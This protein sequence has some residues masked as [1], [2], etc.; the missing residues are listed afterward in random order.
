MR[1]LT[2]ADPAEARRLLDAGEFVWLDLVAP[3]DEELEALGEVLGLHPLAVEDTRELDQ[4]PKTDRYADGV[5]FVFF[6]AVNVPAGA[7]VPVEVHLH[8]SGRHL[9]T[10]RSAPEPSLDALHEHIAADPPRP[11]DATVYRVLDAL[12]DTL[13]PALERQ[14]AVLDAL[15]LEIL[16][17][18]QSE[19]LERLALLRR[20]NATLRRRLTTQHERFAELEAAVLDL[21]GLGDEAR[22]YLRDVG[23]HVGRAAADA[24]A[25]A[26]ALDAL[27]DTYFNAN[28]NRLTVVSERLSVVATVILPLT[29]VTGFFGQNFGWLVDHITSLR[30]FLI[31]G[32]GGLVVP[33]ALALAYLLA[34]R[35][36]LT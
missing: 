9:L 15:S 6:A 1:V 36:E 20:A 23:D 12:A 29:L 14:D 22:P 19:Q 10:V 18:P 11:E 2:Q 7:A 4:R 33:T 35:R 17:R 32:I 13:G 5:L 24:T 34:R 25:Q 3:A 30:S 28:A 16:Q 31:F 26:T 8:A 21:P 27:T